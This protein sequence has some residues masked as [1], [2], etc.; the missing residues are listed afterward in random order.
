MDSLSILPIIATAP[1]AAPD[2][3]EY[4]DGALFGIILGLSLYNLVLYLRLR[5]SAYLYF[6]GYGAFIGGYILTELGYGDFLPWASWEWGARAFTWFSLAAGLSLFCQFTIHFLNT[7]QDHPIAHRMLK[8]L[9]WA[10]FLG[11]ILGVFPVQ[12]DFLKHAG[13]AANAISTLTLLATAT[14]I[15]LL[16]WRKQTT[17]AISYITANGLFCA[18]GI[19]YTLPF[20]GLFPFTNFF[21]YLVQVGIAAQMLI[22]SIGIASRVEKLRHEIAARELENERVQK[23]MT[24]RKARELEEQVEART[25]ELRREKEEVERLLNN[26]L[27]ADIARELRSSGHVEPRRHEEASILFTDFKGFTNTVSTIPAA[28]L[29]Q[30]LNVMFEAF[31]DII[32]RLGLEKMKTIGDAYMIAGGLP[33]AKPNHAV[34]CVR[35]ACE[36]IAF[37]QKRNEI[38]AIKWDIRAGIHSGSVI[39][40]VVG[41]RKFTYDVWG[42]SVNIASRMESA[43]QP[44]KVNLS[45]YSYDLVKEFF[46]CVYRGKVDVKGKGEIDM[47]FVEDEIACPPA[48]E[49]VPSE[50]N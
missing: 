12:E 21:T 36:M 20:F 42:D 23:E 46:N 35:A 43:G 44:G 38:N 2:L 4:F 31:D 49:T 22:F 29:V 7:G 14:L 1:S 41:K 48:T 13:Y 5:D 27:P 33:Q 50:N 16:G 32:E 17:T 40:G 18:A 39:A 26:I 30:E 25:S 15:A 28:R 45:A 47:Y 8:A 19:G 34:A 9:R 37:V 11:P 6:G 24:E 3:Q 10:F